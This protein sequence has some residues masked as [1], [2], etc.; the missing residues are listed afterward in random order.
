VYERDTGAGEGEDGRVKTFYI[1]LQEF[2][3]C[4]YNMIL[5]LSCFG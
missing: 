1:F 5:Y 3:R 2:L 4:I